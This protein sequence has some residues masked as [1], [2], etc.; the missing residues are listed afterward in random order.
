MQYIAANTQ[1]FVEVFNNRF[2][3]YHVITFSCPEEN[4][5]NGKLKYDELKAKLMGEI[6]IDPSS[7]KMTFNSV[8]RIEFN[9]NELHS[10]GEL[11][12]KLENY[13]KQMNNL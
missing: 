9:Y 5:L 10:L 6:Y 8:Y 3:F 12:I 7:L 2:N 13:I 4:F 1:F 11:L